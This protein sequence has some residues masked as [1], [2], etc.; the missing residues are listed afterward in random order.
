M[1]LLESRSK[2]LFTTSQLTRL[3]CSRMKSV[4]ENIRDLLKD[5]TKDDWD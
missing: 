4:A 5:R 3:F 2:E 1:I